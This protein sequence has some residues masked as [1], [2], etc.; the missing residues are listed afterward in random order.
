[1]AEQKTGQK[2]QR[3]KM[4]PMV[5]R[6]ARHDYSILET[7]QA[8]IVLE[9]WEVK[10]ILGRKISLDGAHIYIKNGE[11]FLLNMQLTPVTTTSTHITTES[12]RTRKIMLH[13]KDIM[14][15]QE[16]VQ[17]KTFTLIPLKIYQADN[18]KIKVEVAL[19]KGKKEYDKR[20][21]SKD[22]DVKKELGRLMKHNLSN[23]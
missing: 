15:L 13:K 9:G 6:K 21:A 7:Y 3:K 19:A 5:N 8:G 16:K 18:R 23:A 22:A 10:S 20:Q 1:M 14:K 12:T 11:M 17:E 2:V 4:E